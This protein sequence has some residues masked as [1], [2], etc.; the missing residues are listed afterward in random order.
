M[1]RIANDIDKTNTSTAI[2]SADSV[3]IQYMDIS[4]T[5]IDTLRSSTYSINSNNSTLSNS[6]LPFENDLHQAK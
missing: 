2:S 5:E 3:Y 4:F 1:V 6:P